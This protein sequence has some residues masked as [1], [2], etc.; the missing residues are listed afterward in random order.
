MADLLRNI[1]LP[2]IFTQKEQAPAPLDPKIQA[3]RQRW[4]LVIDPEMT[5]L[6]IP[7]K[8]ERGVLTIEVKEMYPAIVYSLG[9]LRNRI[10]QIFPEIPIHSISLTLK[11]VALD[12]NLKCKAYDSS[13]EEHPL[14]FPPQPLRPPG[15]PEDLKEPQETKTSALDT[16]NYW[17]KAMEIRNSNLPTC[18]DCNMAANPGELERWKRC[19]FCES[20]RVSK[21]QKPGAQPFS[22]KPYLRD[23]SAALA[24]LK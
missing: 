3:L 21:L 19:T 9:L 16:F 12:P 10:N 1:N 15:I 2:G 24:T 22:T 5:P 11:E 8:I 7:L 14:Y 18:P 17:I 4:F 6:A 13:V 23:K 20:T